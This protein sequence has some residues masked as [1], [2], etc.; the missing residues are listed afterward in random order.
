MTSPGPCGD[1]CPAR[2]GQ[3]D[4]VRRMTELL[5]VR[6]H[7]LPEPVG[8]L[9]SYAKSQENVL[10]LI[11]EAALHEDI[12]SGA[13]AGARWH[14]VMEP[15][16]IRRVLQ[17]RVDDYPKSDVS[18]EILRPAVGDSMI[19]V[20]GPDWRRQ[21]RLSAPVFQPRNLSGLGPV[22]EAA[23][24]R[25]VE[26]VAARS[27]EV[28]NVLDE[29]IAT[30][31]EIIADVTF[32]GG[33]GLDRASVVAAMEAYGAAAGKM[34]FLDVLGAPSWVPRPARLRTAPDLQ[35]MKD[36]ADKSIETRRASATEGPPDLLD[37][38]LCAEAEG[39]SQVDVRDNLLAFVMAG[40]ET[41]ALTIAWSLY[42][43][44]GAPEIQA[45]AHEE[46][47]G[48]LQGRTAQAEDV[49][50]LPY[51]RAVV[52]EALRLYPP[53]AFLSRTAREPD[54]I[55]GHQILPGDTVTVPIYAVHRHRK[56]WDAP[57]AF[58]PERFAQ[59]KNIPRYAYLPFGD[60]P[61]ICIGARF[62]VQEA[63]VVLASLLSRFRF[64][65]VPGKAPRP[66][67]I[68]TLRPEGGVWLRA[69]AVS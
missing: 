13:N 69:D 10:E 46:A 4:Y 15:N 22:M 68:I 66:S 32:S 60:G 1:I 5:P 27:G 20:D 24:A 6:A 17:A 61:R 56:L 64:T 43:L 55:L 62:A 3:P 35:A 57:D 19:N 26:R 33:M 40:H 16:A 8:I 34:S 14:M 52:D 45:R 58:D 37:L 63:M 59:R 12:L 23:A 50:H 47:R 11:P 65:P 51:L 54:D 30:T 28:V 67:L 39:F 49:D 18:K 36:L 21:R 31:F 9:T 42:L 53:G 44:G 38:L 2:L 29:A 41:T 48:L 25:A 7:L